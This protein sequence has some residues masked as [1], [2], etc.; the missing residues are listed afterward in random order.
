MFF[1]CANLDSQAVSRPGFNLVVLFL[2]SS[3]LSSIHSQVSAKEVGFMSW[4]RQTWF[5]NITTLSSRFTIP[6]NMFSSPISPNSN[7]K[8]A[9]KFSSL[10]WWSDFTVIFTITA[11]HHIHGSQTELSYTSEMFSSTYSCFVTTTMSISLSAFKE[12]VGWHT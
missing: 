5:K 11:Q 7:K 2:L 12:S 4:P 9:R 3:L 6:L 8:F 10:F 1:K